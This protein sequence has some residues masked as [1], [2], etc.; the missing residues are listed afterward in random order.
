[1]LRAGRDG[2]MHYTLLAELAHFSFA[3]Y[4]RF[5][6]ISLLMIHYWPAALP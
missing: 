4:A 2:R 5:S 1:M 3:G 6:Y